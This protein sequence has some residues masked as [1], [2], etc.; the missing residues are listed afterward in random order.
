VTPDRRVI[1]VARY[2]LAEHT[3]SRSFVAP[4]VVL[5]GGVIV[6]YAQP[7]N[8]VLSTGGTVAA[9]LFPIGCWIAL[10]FFNSQGTADRRLLAATVGGARFV[11]GRLLAAASLAAATSLFALAIPLIGGAFERTPRLDELGLLLAANAT[12]TIGATAL[13]I[14]FS[15]PIVRSRAIAVLGLTACVLATIPLRLP[16][17]IPTARALDTARAGRVPG[18]IAADVLVVL[19]FAIAAT[20]LGAWQWRRRE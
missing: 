11:R 2:L 17:F 7:P 8:P 4:L 20:L 10:A 3:H 5:V 19:A 12:S 14:A 13:A 9:F 1:A 16:P 15:A 18:R 6:L